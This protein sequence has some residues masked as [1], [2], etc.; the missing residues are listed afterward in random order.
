MATKLTVTGVLNVSG[1]G[2]DGIRNESGA[3]IDLSGATVYASDN[4]GNGLYSNGEVALGDFT[5]HRNG[6]SG[7]LLVDL[8]LKAEL[9]RQLSLPDEFPLE[10]V[11]NAM[12]D[13]PGMA[14]QERE[15]LLKH[16]L[17]F[18]ALVGTRA[19]EW[20]TLAANLVAVA[21]TDLGKAVLSTVFSN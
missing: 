9:Y 4:K 18:V 20:S 17:K 21:N 1:N 19:V 14:P 16:S 11:V 10:D 6:E 3:A 2:R 12:R 13:L 15:S 5:A 8:E 7:I